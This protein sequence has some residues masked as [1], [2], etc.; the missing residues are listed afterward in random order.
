MQSLFYTVLHNHTDTNNIL[1]SYFC[2]DILCIT[3]ANQCHKM[4][5]KQ[6]AIAF[7]ILFSYFIENKFHTQFSNN[8]FATKIN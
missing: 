1:C 5:I 2:I 6:F 3:K 4:L 7:Y 8:Y